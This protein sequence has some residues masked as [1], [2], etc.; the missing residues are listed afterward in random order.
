MLRNLFDLR[1]INL[2]KLM[3]I[4]TISVVNIDAHLDVRPL[5]DEKAHS[6]SPFRLLLEDNQFTKTSS[7]FVE[8]AAQGSQCSMEHAR[9]VTEKHGQVICWLSNLRRDSNISIAER[10]V[11]LL[12]ELPGNVFISFDLDSIQGS[13]APGVS[14]ASPTGL[15]AQEALEIS[16]ETGKCSKVQLFD[17]SEYNPLV[18][19]YRTGRLVAMM[20]YYF[21]MGLACRKASPAISQKSYDMLY[22]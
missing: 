17:V 11:G 1:I 3:I 22:I 18:E 8:F 5:K 15:T 10:F 9:F 4:S 2:F 7:R 12:E 20:F 13:D 16:F 6:G 14:C 21:C 19:D